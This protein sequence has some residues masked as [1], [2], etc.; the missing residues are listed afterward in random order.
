MIALTVIRGPRTWDRRDL[1]NRQSVWTYTVRTFGLR[2]MHWRRAA[3]AVTGGEL[4]RSVPSY[5]VGGTVRMCFPDMYAF[6]TVFLDFSSF[7]IFLFYHHRCLS[8]S[9]FTTCMFYRVKHQ[10]N[11]D[12]ALMIWK[13]NTNQARQSC[14]LDSN[15][16]A[17]YNIYLRKSSIRKLLLLSLLLYVK[18]FRLG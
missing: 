18:L 8:T 1:P 13:N 15:F 10:H 9:W 4:L 17:N 2:R 14:R 6:P 11:I 16:Q 7:S 12:I 5:S 3:A